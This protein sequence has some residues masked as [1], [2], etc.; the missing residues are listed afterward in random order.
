MLNVMHEIWKFEF[1]FNI[2][3]IFKLWV[4]FKQE[5][6]LTNL[7]RIF[8]ERLNLLKVSIHIFPKSRFFITGDLK[9]FPITCQYISASFY[10][11]TFRQILIDSSTL[12]LSGKSFR[13]TSNTWWW[14][15]CLW[16]IG[17]W[18]FFCN[19]SSN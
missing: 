4:I 14:Y 16:S 9:L 17:R 10:C 12:Y 2:S 11:S 5:R 18:R 13:S 19:R 3:K 6:I 7:C 1:A 15:K 8:S